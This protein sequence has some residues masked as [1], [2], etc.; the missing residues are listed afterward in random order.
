MPL[1]TN[2]SME[3]VTTTLFITNRLAQANAEDGLTPQSWISLI[4][5]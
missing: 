1:K 2:D 5:R 3:K 4:R